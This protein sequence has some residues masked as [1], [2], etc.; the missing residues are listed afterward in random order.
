MKS[1]KKQTVHPTVTVAN[2]HTQSPKL[3]VRQMNGNRVGANSV[4]SIS[5]N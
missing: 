4:Y 5:G 1:K 3:N 2:P